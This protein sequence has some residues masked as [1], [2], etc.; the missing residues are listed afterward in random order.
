MRIPVGAGGSRRRKL[1]TNT[2]AVFSYR[3]PGGEL[4]VKS[5]V[6]PKAAFDDRD[7]D[8]GFHPDSVEYRSV[9]HCLPA[10]EC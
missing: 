8:A 5:V 7:P 10:D 4:A 1:S 3:T 2:A 6:S 9:R